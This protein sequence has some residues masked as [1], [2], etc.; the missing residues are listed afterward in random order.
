MPEHFVGDQ[1]ELIE[2]GVG[3]LDA[4]P[5]RQ[6]QLVDL[7]LVELLLILIALIDQLCFVLQ[8][9]LPRLRYLQ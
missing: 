5:R 1:I 3:G 2:P 8:E 4:D 6:R 7:E 9:L